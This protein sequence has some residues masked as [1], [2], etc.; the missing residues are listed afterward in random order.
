M[1]PILFNTEMVRANLDGRKNTTRRLI[2]PKY[3]DDECGFQVITNAHTGEF[4]RVEK[5][6]DQGAGMFPDGTE[7]RLIAQF[8]PWYRAYRCHVGAC[9]NMEVR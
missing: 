9:E 3:R 7:K 2:K 6:S 1:K 4:I 8:A 5:I